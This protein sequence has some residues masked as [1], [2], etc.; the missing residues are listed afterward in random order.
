MRSKSDVENRYLLKHAGYPDMQENS[1]GMT[2]NFAL[3]PSCAAAHDGPWWTEIPA[4]RR[5]LFQRSMDGLIHTLDAIPDNPAAFS[6][7][8]DVNQLTN[9]HSIRS[10][11]GLT[12]RRLRSVMPLNGVIQLPQF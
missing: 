1:L 4:H 5:H 2:Y 6:K 7:S 8:P 3:A 9:V 11:D 10:S 12:L